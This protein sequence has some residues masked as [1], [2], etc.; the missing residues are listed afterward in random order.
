MTPA[1]I[2]TM[3]RE[4]VLDGTWTADMAEQLLSGSA[5]PDG[6][7]AE[8]KRQNEDS[9]VR[10]A[11]AQILSRPRRPTRA[12]SDQAR[13]YHGR[14]ARG[15]GAAH[16]AA[17]VEHVR[18]EA[19][20]IARVSGHADHVARGER[21][22]AK[23]HAAIANEHRAIAAGHIAP[24]P[25]AK[26]AAYDAA[27]AHAQARAA[28]IKQQLDEHQGRTAHA[29]GALRAHP[30]HGDLHDPVDAHEHAST[31][32]GSVAGHGQTTTY[33]PG[34][35]ESAGTYREHADRAQTALEDLHGHQTRATSELRHV[36]REHGRAANAMQ[37]EAERH[38]EHGVRVP[39][40]H[41]GHEAARDAAESLAG[42]EA[43]RRGD[44]S[45]EMRTKL[46][47]AHDALREAARSTAQT[48]RELSKI[49]GRA[50][51]LVG[52]R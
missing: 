2:G 15:H 27:H 43:T 45:S 28:E 52:R 29:L 36:D 38:A 31:Q 18:A 4:R 23:E 35:H 5:D 13:D 17:R 3:Y 47:D 10:S 19:T 24:V 25:T 7:V 30:D 37:R 34:H 32:L 8:F 41:P 44:L 50:P 49:T 26:L 40:E 20:S 51:R 21:E 22:A 48:V 33:A 46:E 39:E 6:I 42:H 16:D 12:D 1:E 11:L 14:F 9:K